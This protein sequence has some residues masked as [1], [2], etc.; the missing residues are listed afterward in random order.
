M[1]TAFLHFEH[2]GLLLLQGKA[3]ASFLVFTCSC[4]HEIVWLRSISWDPTDYHNKE[5]NII[6]IIVP[7][8]GVV[9]F[10]QSLLLDESTYH[11]LIAVSSAAGTPSDYLWGNPVT[12]GK[13]VTLY[14]AALVQVVE[15]KAS[16]ITL[17]VPNGLSDNWFSI[18]GLPCKDNIFSKVTPLVTH[19]LALTDVGGGIRLFYKDYML[20]E[21]EGVKENSCKCLWTYNGNSPVI[22]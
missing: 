3:Y 18:K 9:H 14:V 5:S 16:S 2:R 1:L 17:E 21:T 10:G 19:V 7:I 22:L 4:I 13:C 12:T 20:E 8:K 15:V 11:I 6:N